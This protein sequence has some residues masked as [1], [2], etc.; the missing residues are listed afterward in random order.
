MCVNQTGSENLCHTLFFRA[1]A[2]ICAIGSRSRALTPIP[3]PH[4]HRGPGH[5]A[6]A[7]E[8]LSPFRQPPL[9]SRYHHHP[10]HLCNVIQSWVLPLD[11]VPA[12]AALPPPSASALGPRGCSAIAGAA[13]LDPVPACVAV[14]PPPACVLGPGGCSAIAGASVLGPGGCSGIA[15]SRGAPPSRGAGPWG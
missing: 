2:A 6:I 1:R 11:P 12:C 9:A 3:W 15:G 10:R 14:P 7:E 4:R 8:N 13:V 5:T